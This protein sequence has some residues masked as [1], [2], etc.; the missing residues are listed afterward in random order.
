MKNRTY[1]W[2]DERVGYEAK[3]WKHT[4]GEERDGCNWI[5][6]GI[7]VG[8]SLQKFQPPIIAIPYRAM[9]TQ[10]NLDRPQSPSKN[11]VQTIREIDGCGSLERRA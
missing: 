2:Y 6:Y 7:D 11:L 8:N 4:I 9:S 3:S 5:D 1:L 10:K